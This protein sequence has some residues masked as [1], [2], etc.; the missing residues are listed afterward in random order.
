M[1]NRREFLRNGAHLG[2][3]GAVLAAAGLPARS[4]AAT[5]ASGRKFIFVFAQGGWDPTRVFATEY[6]NSA[7]AMEPDGAL[8][9]VG[10]LSFV[11]HPARPSVRTFFEA[12]HADTVV[13]N[14]VMVRSIAHEICTMIAMTGTT[15]GVSPDWPAAIA[16]ADREA[17]TLPHLVLGGPSFPGS[18][19]VAVARTG[20]SGQLEALLSR[21]ALGWTDTPVGSTMKAPS[22]KVV[23]RWMARRAAARADASRSALERSLTQDYAASLAHLE[24]LKDLA[25][26]ID[27]TAGADLDAQA[28]VAADAL[29]M[30]VSRCVTLNAGT[31]GA[32]DTH[33][34]NDALQSPP[35]ESTFAGLGQLLERLRQTPGTSAATLAEETVVVLLSEMGRTPALNGFAGKDH[36]PFTSMLLWGDGLVGDRV[37]GGFDPNYYGFNID[38][39]SG[40]VSDGGEVLSAEAVGATLLALADVDPAEY[41][42]VDP[43]MGVVA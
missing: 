10:N 38:P 15:S 26:S 28:Q 42:D 29:S 14:G 4:F 20:A 30:G 7:V 35:W 22:E 17:F 1:L 43:I 12:N 13:F 39:A 5:P 27:F 31:P 41:V 34:N 16:G 11:D 24:D 2:V 21:R 25:W 3:G 18:L 36:W 23:D 33:T 32:W 8:A 19:G 6:A 40:D 37:I 9:T